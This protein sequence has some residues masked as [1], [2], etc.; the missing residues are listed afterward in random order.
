MS[1]RF[2]L[3]AVAVFVVAGPCATGL[4]AQAPRN[5]EAASSVPT[6]ERQPYDTRAFMAPLALTEA[7]RNGRRLVAQRCANCHGANPRQ[8]G[9]LL[10]KPVVE[11]RG[12]A[13]IRD[14]VKKGSTLMPGF[15]HTLQ[16]AQIDEI[17][18]F[19]RTY[20]PPPRSAPAA[21]E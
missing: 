13:F 17:I 8:P 14:K 19:L 11:G 4:G 21:Q 10:G 5:G 9:P 16:P 3:V 12:E 2:A 18:S 7:E 20:T 15:E 6:V 1:A